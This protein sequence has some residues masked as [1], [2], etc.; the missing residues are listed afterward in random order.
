M[1]ISTAKFSLCAEYLS[2]SMGE[3][4]TC[5]LVKIVRRLFI[6]VHS[7]KTITYLH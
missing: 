2:G 6:S 5:N 3:K 1:R 4:L 7:R